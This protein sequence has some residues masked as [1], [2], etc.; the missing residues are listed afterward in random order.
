VSDTVTTD[1]NLP[2]AITTLRVLL[3]PVVTV[4]LFESGPAARLIAF[5]VFLVA[6]V[7][8]LVD[9]A[10]ARRRK[11]V[12]DFGKLVDPL[13]DKLLLVATLIPF[14]LLTGRNLDLAGLPLFGGI[15]LWVLVVFFG[16]ELLIT[17]LRTAAAR[18]G[19]VVPARTLGKRKAFAQNVF[20]GSMILWIAYR[21]AAVEYG[22]SGAFDRFWN[23]L[24]G[25]F[26]TIA[27]T[28]ALLLTV[29][30]LIAYLVTFRR[31]LRGGTA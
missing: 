1:V 15:S 22:W 6:A 4:L 9:G 19:V 2:N 8:D 30:S 7:S 16:R 25:W 5:G 23:G 3:A 20:I 18:R 29:L 14:F 12:T 13:A 26:T 28:A 11:E 24:H 31:V 10:L 21:T 17:W 27:L